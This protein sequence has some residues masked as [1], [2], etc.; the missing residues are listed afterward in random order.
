MLRVSDAAGAAYRKFEADFIFLKDW[1]SDAESIF[2]ATR[3]V[4][5][6]STVVE[7]MFLIQNAACVFGVSS[8]EYFLKGLVA[9]QTGV[10][11]DTNVNDLRD[12][13]RLLR[14]A[15]LISLG[16]ILQRRIPHLRFLFAWRHLIVHNGNVPDARFRRRISDI[17]GPVAA[18]GW[19]RGRAVDLD[20]FKTR[21]FDNAETCGRLI[22]EAIRKR[23]A[24]QSP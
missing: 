16:A 8:I 15:W 24:P 2:N 12:A 14:P 11:P 3:G 17:W 1:L 22:Y 7:R 19:T 6:R 5:A 13:E 4:G 18:A 10:W 23:I 20:P 21:D 9:A